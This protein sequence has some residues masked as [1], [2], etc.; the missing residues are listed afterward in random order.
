MTSKRSFP[1]LLLLCQATTPLTF[2]LV[3]STMPLWQESWKETKAPSSLSSCLP[4][5]ALLIASW[6]T[7]ATWKQV[8]VLPIMGRQRGQV[9]RGSLWLY[10]TRIM[11]GAMHIH[12]PAIRIHKDPILSLNCWL[13]YTKKVC[14]MHQFLSAHGGCL[15]QLTPS[16]AAASHLA[17]H[18]S[19]FHAKKHRRKTGTERR[20]WRH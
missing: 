3:R 16:D 10:C 5:E 6:G 9:R 7:D 19:E 15:I 13:L 1:A 14:A 8:M 2:S 20:T 11:V 17:F 12:I 18:S 4:G